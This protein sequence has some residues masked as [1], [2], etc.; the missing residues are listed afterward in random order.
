MTD[1]RTSTDIDWEEE[2]ADDPDFQ[3]IP[4]ERRAR[5]IEFLERAMEL[6]LGAVY[7]DEDPDE[8]DADVDCASLTDRCQARCCTLIF[9][10]TKEEVA[11]GKVRWNPKRPYFIARDEDGYCPHLERGTWRCQVWADR[12]LRCRRYDCRHDEYIWPD[13]FPRDD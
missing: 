3:A 1:E 11:A 13:G 8:P 9:A 2:F 5:L 6:G 12:P 7:G 10:L 4:P